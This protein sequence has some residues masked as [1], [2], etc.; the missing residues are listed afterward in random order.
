MRTLDTVE[1]GEAAAFAHDTGQADAEE[2]RNMGETLRDA[3]REGEVLPGL[4][5]EREEPPQQ[6]PQQRQE[7]RPPHPQPEAKQLE[8]GQPKGPVGKTE[9]E[10][11][12]PPLDAQVEVP[13][14]GGPLPPQGSTSAVIDLT[15]DD[16]PSN[17]GKQKADVKMVDASDRP[18]TSVAP[19]G[20]AVEASGGCP[21]TQFV[22]CVLDV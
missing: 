1:A 22:P 2:T 11:V 4:Q 16:S 9:R 18:R 15:F 20:D 8:L 3:G 10:V 7:E 12:M 19:D 21:V 13:A 6:P 14:S 17:K 5:T